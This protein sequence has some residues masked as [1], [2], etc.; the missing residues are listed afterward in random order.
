MHS[1]VLSD[2]LVRR[3]DKD[4]LDNRHADSEGAGD[5]DLPHTHLC[6]LMFNHRYRM[7]E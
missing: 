1:N 6:V 2:I 3:E 5:S 4:L 7:R